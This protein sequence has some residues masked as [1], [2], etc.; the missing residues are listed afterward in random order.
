MRTLILATLLPSVLVLM[1]AVCDGTKEAKTHF[2]AA[3]DLQEQ[4]HLDGAIQGFNEA[5][6]LDPERAEAY[7]RQ[8]DVYKQA[9][10]YERA[11]QDYDEA[12][13]FGSQS[14][15]LCF[16]ARIFPRVCGSQRYNR[17][18]TLLRCKRL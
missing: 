9:G 8:G 12:V 15:R 5:I 13:R 10:H 17:P 2:N 4:G 6:P 14:G 7:E 18:G 1:L 16:T 11:L 3:A